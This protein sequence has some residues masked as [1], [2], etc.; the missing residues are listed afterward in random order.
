VVNYD[1]PWNPNRL[2]QRFGR[3]HRIGQEQPCHMWSL[4]ASDTREADVFETLLR[5]LE[6]ERKALPGYV[7]DV[8]GQAFR[9]RSLRDLLIEAI[10]HGDDPEVQARIRAEVGQLTDLDRIRRLA[11]EQGLVGGQELQP[12]TVQEVRERLLRASAQ[13][14]QPHH[15]GSFFREAFRALGGRMRER[16]PGRYEITHVPLDVRDRARALGARAPVLERY[17]RITFEPEKMQGAPEAAFVCPGHGLFDAVLDVV[18]ERHQALLKRGLVL[19]DPGDW[20][21]QPSWIWYLEHEITCGS[22]RTV[23]KQLLFLRQTPDGTCHPAGAAPHLDL[24]PLDAGQ[25]KT[26]EPVLAELAQRPSAEQAVLSHAIAEVVPRHLEEVKGQHEARVSK[27]MQA[28]RERLVR[29][30]QFWDRR[31]QQLR[32]EEKAGKQP[33]MNAD[34]AEN[35]AKELQERL[36]RRLKDLEAERQVSAKPPVLLGGA[37]IVPQGLLLRLGAEDTAA[38]AQARKTK[39]VEELAVQAVIAYE[40]GLDN[41]PRSVE[42]DKCGY[43][44]E[45]RTSA[46]DLRFID[47]K[48][49]VE[50]GDTITVTRNEVVTALNEPER[51]IL[52]LVRVN[53]DRADEPQYVIRPFGREPDFG[54][55]AVTYRIRDLLRRDGPSGVA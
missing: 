14:V 31:A 45:S 50:E 53:G 55:S 5:K 46:G 9:E 52:A 49:R 4:L 6:A 1:L 17:E 7:F 38:A 13:R 48:G 29:Q 27:T 37:L 16:E 2:E 12:A 44:V 34:R 51:F 24:K 36:E 10:R 32:E 40:R 18:L 3:V 43:D 26:L 25:W 23:S 30:I 39:R 15:I 19:L 33:R 20:G 11:A 42:R 54:V 21:E 8:L 22:G 28:V 47:V 35:R 41:K